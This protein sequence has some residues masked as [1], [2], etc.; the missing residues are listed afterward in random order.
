M[1]GFI[2]ASSLLQLSEWRGRIRRVQSRRPA[3]SFGGKDR[4]MS[5]Y[6][7]LG[8]VA[9]ALMVAT[10]FAVVSGAAGTALADTPPNNAVTVQGT[11]VVTAPADTAVVR[12]GV[13]VQ[14]Q[15]V[16]SARSQAATAAASVVAAVKADGV[17]D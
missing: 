8:M 4:Q 7:R 6:R 17:A 2:L 13:E 3:A 1:N 9:L 10:A 15:T 12:L 14:A 5:G 16:A 11:G